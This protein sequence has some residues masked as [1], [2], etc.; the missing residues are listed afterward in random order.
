MVITRMSSYTTHQVTRDSAASVQTQ[1]LKLQKQISSGY[2]S[3]SFQ[4]LS[5]EAE[6]FLALDSKM[7]RTDEFMKNNQ[8][9]TARMQTMSSS[10]GGAIDI[11]TNLRNTLLLRRNQSVADSLS[12]SQQLDAAFKTI[13]AQLNTSLEGRYLFGGTRTDT[14]PVDSSGI[15]VIYNDQGLPEDGYYQGTKQNTTMRLQ[16]D[17]T[18]AQTVRADDPAIQKIFTAMA[19]AKKGNEQDDDTM[20]KQAYDML[21]DGLSGLNDMQ[22]T[23]G[24]TVS[25][26]NT[27]AERQ[28]QLKTYWQGVKESLVNTDLISAST[29]VATN[30]GILQAS[31]QAFAR[32]NSLQLSDFLR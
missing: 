17:Y 26:M 2:K 21:S 8:I 7:S 5:A 16:D 11:T 31:F 13:A 4:G 32:I 14:P 10:V 15:P 27:V 18:L 1:L 6:G 22:T 25:A 3:D 23:I 28:S 12:F 30:Q 19:I 29:E 9:L 24:N 20:L